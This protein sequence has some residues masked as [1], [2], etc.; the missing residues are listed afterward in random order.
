MTPELALFQTNGPVFLLYHICWGG[1]GEIE[2]R[3]MKERG[4]G[5]HK[6]GESKEMG[7]EKM[8]RRKKKDGRKREQAER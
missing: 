8:M 3:G 1:G 5:E 6:E 2:R 4:R 7:G